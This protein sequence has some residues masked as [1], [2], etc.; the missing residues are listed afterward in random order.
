VLKC[1]LLAVLFLFAAQCSEA[2][3]PTPQIWFGMRGVDTPEHRQ[4]WDRL[5]FQPDAVWPDAL[6]RVDVI[7]AAAQTLNRL[8]EGELANLA[9]RLKQHH[10]ALDV[11]VLAQ[12]W[13][14][15]P[16][17]GRG[18]EGYS[19]PAANVKLAAKLQRAGAPV[20]YIGMDE[21]LFFGHYYNGKNACHSSIDNVV[22]RVSVNLREYLKV[23]PNATIVDAEPFPGVSNHAGWQDDYKSWMAA[24]HAAVG[25]PIGGL[26][27]DINWPPQWQ[28]TLDSVVTFARG[29]RLPIGI[30]YWA[31]SKGA[32]GADVTNEQW[33]SSAEQNFTQIEKVMGIIPDRAIFASW[34]KFPRHSISDG[35]GPGEDYLVERYLLI[36]NRN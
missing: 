12:N 25:R 31:E 34:S 29:Q 22:E 7:I 18:V 1:L 23:Y 2:A 15:E 14:N 4:D 36:K 10:V 26:N 28:Q 24:F 5:F 17:C 21:P 19:T 6:T 35:N 33:L 20:S 13:V 8:S 30:F 32:P 11:A 27:I 3:V 9:A 16:E